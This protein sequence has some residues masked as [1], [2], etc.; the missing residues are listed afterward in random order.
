M[1]ED[2]GLR[3]LYFPR[4]TDLSIHTARDLARVESELKQAAADV[5]NDRSPDDLFTAC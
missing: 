1:N 2:N 5:L 4:S 3:S